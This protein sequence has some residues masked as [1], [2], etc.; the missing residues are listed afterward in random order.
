MRT[1]EARGCA[2]PEPLDVASS[3]GGRDRDVGVDG[4]VDAAVAGHRGVSGRLLVG[5]GLTEA[6]GGDDPRSATPAS[7]NAAAAASAR[8]WLSARFS[9]SVPR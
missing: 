1:I 6:D 8:S 9:A 3:T 2:P 5:T 7:T 4:D